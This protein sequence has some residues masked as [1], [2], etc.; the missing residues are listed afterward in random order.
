M[1][2]HPNFDPLIPSAQARRTQ[3]GGMSRQTLWR[4]HRDGEVTIVRIGRR[5]Y[6]QASEID[7][8]LD[9]RRSRR[10]R[11]D[12]GPVVAEPSVEETADEPGDS[13]TD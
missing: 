12:E 5:V 7:R 11:N 13:L 6:L 8:F 1:A 9:E 3:L 2:T 10:P 4:L